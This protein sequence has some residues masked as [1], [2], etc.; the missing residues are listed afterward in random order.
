MNRAG[1]YGDDF[2]RRFTANVLSQETSVR[3][4]LAKVALDEVDAGIVYVT[5]AQTVADRVR[6]VD[7]PDRL[8]VVAEYPIAVLARSSLKAAAG[9]F[10]A[11]V[12]S[13]RGQTILARHGF[14]AFR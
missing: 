2:Q 9:R 10:V 6:V 13:E 4:V 11:L 12:T 8:N 1:L 5:D 3:A 14:Q 7:I